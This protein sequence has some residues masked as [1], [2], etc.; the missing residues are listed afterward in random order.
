MPNTSCQSLFTQRIQF[1]WSY[2]GHR[3]CPKLVKF[4]PQIHAVRDRVLRAIF[5]EEAAGLSVIREFWVQAVET[6]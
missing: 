1:G 2:S 6:L 3:E 5:A 4:L